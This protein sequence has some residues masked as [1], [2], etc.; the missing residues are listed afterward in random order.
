MC[1]IEN[2]KDALQKA[3]KERKYYSDKKFVR[4]A[5]GIAYGGMLVT[6]DTLMEIKNIKLPAK[7]RKSIE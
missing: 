5:S 4:S 6:L 7:S 2:A 3:K 1:Y